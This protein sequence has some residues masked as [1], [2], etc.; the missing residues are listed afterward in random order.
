M[1]ISRVYGASRPSIRKTLR[2]DGTEIKKKLPDGSEVSPIDWPTHWYG[3]TREVT[4]DTVAALYDG[5][6]PHEYFVLGGA[7]DGQYVTRLRR[8]DFRLPPTDLMVLDV[9]GM[10]YVEG[11]SD[12]T[13]R[14]DP[15]NTI[16]AQLAKMFGSYSDQFHIVVALSSRA[17][18]TSDFR[19]HVW[20]GV[21]P[22][23][24]AKDIAA[25]QKKQPVDWL[26]TGIFQAGRVLFAAPPDTETDPFPTR[27]FEFKGD[28]L[29]V[30]MYG[31]AQST[32][33]LVELRKQFSRG[34]H[35]LY[36]LNTGPLDAGEGGV[37]GE[38]WNFI[39]SCKR[40]GM[41]EDDAIV[42]LH[43]EFTRLDVPDA[44]WKRM[45]KVI[46]RPDGMTD[47]A[48]GEAR[49]MYRDMRAGETL[50]FGVP[51]YREPET[52]LTAASEALRRA[53][54]DQIDREG[55]FLNKVTLGVGKTHEIVELVTSR[56]VKALILAPNHE[57]CTEI[58]NRLNDAREKRLYD[59]FDQVGQFEEIEDRWL[60]RPWESWRGRSAEGICSRLDAV[61]AAFRAGVSVH[62]HICGFPTPDE[63]DDVKRCPR[64]A[65]C[66]YADQVMNFW[67]YNWVAPVAMISHLSRIASDADVVIIDEG[68]VEH[69]AGNKVVPLED[70]LAPRPGRLGELSRKAHCDLLED[71][72]TLT[73]DEVQEALELE[74][75]EKPAPHVEPDMTDEQIIANC[76]PGSYRAG[77]VSIW[78]AMLARM[79]GGENHLHVFAETKKDDNGEESTRWWVDVAWRRKPRL[80]EKVDTVLLFDA[81]PNEVALRAHWPELEVFEVEAPKLNTR[82][83]QVTDAVGK[84]SQLINDL[85]K[86]DPQFKAEETRVK[87]ARQR[88]A[89]WLRAQPGY[90]VVVTKK[91]H[92]EAIEKEH[93]FDCVAFAHHGAVEGKDIWDF[94]DGKRL[95]GVDVDNL[96]ILGRN[97][98]QPYHLE[99][100]ARRHHADEDAVKTM[101]WYRTENWELGGGVAGYRL[102][103]DDPRVDAV[104]KN[105][106]V[107]SLMQ[108]VG[109]MR[110]VRREKM[111]RV[112]VMHSMRLDIEVDECVSA[113]QVMRRT[114]DVTLLSA[115]EVDRVFGA[116]G[117]NTREIAKRVTATHK[118]RMKDKAAQPK[119]YLCAVAAGAD[120][121]QCMADM[122]AVWWEAVSAE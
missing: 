25:F 35:G 119:P 23:C 111:G 108:A 17:G 92:R 76:E 69:L 114:G 118:Y 75:E 85:P 65:T 19:A 14:A 103:H 112:F 32:D 58:V 63:G 57:R 18:F 97:A 55:V 22:R 16:R 62:K 79:E 67:R 106:A 54:R 91:D 102:R 27:V 38:C 101:G 121:D 50:V 15:E 37:S 8:T 49:R 89:D 90:T 109:R 45:R 34:K 110:S 107:D 74:L 64:F 40:A 96:V 77:C 13:L 1:R 66:A 39:L 94:P 120:V 113:E 28:G 100:I 73:F 88:L 104:L 31:D 84:R 46:K 87:K 10:P 81:T 44:T 2:P 72:Q 56:D 41:S 122:G 11:H 20:V 24:T 98:P 82:V 48:L 116:G 59:A 36:K 68:C 51:A 47:P 21:S 30:D 78:R 42:A 71:T 60:E 52:T 33:G 115:S 43:D 5:I 53:V 86:T 7:P 105:V 117:R 9:D 70:L 95:H 61:N 4:I 6:E 99:A 12:E 29:V 26:D 93:R 3:T 80:L 83:V